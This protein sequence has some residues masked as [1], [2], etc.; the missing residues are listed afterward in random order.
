MSSTN[1]VHLFE[2]TKIWYFQLS[3]YLFMVTMATKTIYGLLHASVLYLEYI[4]PN[5]NIL[6]YNKSKPLS[7]LKQKI[8][9]CK[10]ESKLKSAQQCWI[11]HT[12]SCQQCE[13]VAFY[14]QSS[15][16]SVKKLVAYKPYANIWH[17][18]KVR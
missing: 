18:A 7:L 12:R 17:H 16:L 2:K 5:I 14:Y 9:S 15:S 13:V 6:A 10:F 8:I 1:E 4:V 11:N 3:Q